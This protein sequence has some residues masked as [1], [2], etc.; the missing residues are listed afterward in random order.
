MLL[1]RKPQQVVNLCEVQPHRLKLLHIKA[2]R[3]EPDNLMPEMKSLLAG[4]IAVDPARIMIL[5]D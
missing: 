4:L 3:S 1:K 2:G 5:C